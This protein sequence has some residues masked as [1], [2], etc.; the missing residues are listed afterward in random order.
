MIAITP[1]ERTEGNERTLAAIY[2]ENPR[3]PNLS[4]ALSHTNPEVKAIAEAL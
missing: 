2:P 4:A 1:K 3:Y